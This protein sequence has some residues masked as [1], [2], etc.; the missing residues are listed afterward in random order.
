MC[1][2]S[3]TSCRWLPRDSLWRTPSTGS[4]RRTRTGG[5]RGGGIRAR[6]LLLYSSILLLLPPSP[7]HLPLHSPITSGKP[8]RKSMRGLDLSPAETQWN[9]IPLA[10]TYSWEPREGSSR[11]AGGTGEGRNRILRSLYIK[12]MLRVAGAYVATYRPGSF[13]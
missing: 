3:L 2:S 7:P 6:K 4:A 8:C 9:L 12:P 11:Q 1:T 5:K 10:V 13:S